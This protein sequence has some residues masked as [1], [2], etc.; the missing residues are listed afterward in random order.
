MLV[1][2]YECEE[3]KSEEPEAA[4]EAVAL[5]ERLELE[6]QLSLSSQ[7][8]G[9]RFPYRK[10][11]SEEQFVYGVICPKRTPLKKYAD[12]AIPLRVLQVAA[13]AVH[14]FDKDL[15]VWHK[16][17]PAVKD[18][19]L[20]GLKMNPNGWGEPERFILA[21]WGGVLEE[22]PALLKAAMATWKSH[23]R[24]SLGKLKSEIDSTLASIDSMGISGAMKFKKPEFD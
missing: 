11:D 13:H 9:E 16:D 23:T 5:I 4:A 24:D 18:P 12:G 1:E 2:T 20:V 19:V 6:G 15:E 3:T 8:P 21:R 14:F 10:M 22:W 7:K 17:T